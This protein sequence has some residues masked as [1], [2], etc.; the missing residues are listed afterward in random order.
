MEEFQYEMNGYKYTTD[1][2]AEVYAKLK[3][4]QILI[5]TGTRMARQAEE[6]IKFYRI[7]NE[8]ADVSGND[9]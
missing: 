3:T 6:T 7:T 4:A 8:I 1:Q 9:K 5:E 2:M